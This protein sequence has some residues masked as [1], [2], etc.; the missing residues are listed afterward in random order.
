MSA[1]KNIQNSSKI[2]SHISINTTKPNQLNWQS[3]VAIIDCW[4]GQAK[5]FSIKKKI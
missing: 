2:I 4:Q 5:M 1:K 3:S